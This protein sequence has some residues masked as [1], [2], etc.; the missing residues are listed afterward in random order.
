MGKK[1]RSRD[2]DGNYAKE[3]PDSEILRVIASTGSVNTRGIAATVDYSESG[4]RKRVRELASKGEIERTE[5][6]EWAL[7]KSDSTDDPYVF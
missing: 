3:I 4:V 6:G 2:D 7:P 1:D 5:N